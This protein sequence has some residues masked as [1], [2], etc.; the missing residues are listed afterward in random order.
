MAWG[1]IKAG[2]RWDKVGKR[3]QFSLQ[4]CDLPDG[5]IA[6]HKWRTLFL[7]QLHQVSFLL[8]DSSLHM[9]IGLTGIYCREL[10][11]PTFPP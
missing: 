6:L 3:A 8:T 1:I 9:R 5:K 7:A 2:I 11:T 10:E 4:S